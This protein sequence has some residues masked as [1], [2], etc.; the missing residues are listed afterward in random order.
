MLTLTKLAPAMYDQDMEDLM[1]NAEEGEG[2]VVSVGMVQVLS[3]KQEIENLL[4]QHKAYA[5]VFGEIGIH[6][7]TLGAFYNTGRWPLLAR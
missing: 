1:E 7:L 5:G 6:A 4:R 3:R 2:S